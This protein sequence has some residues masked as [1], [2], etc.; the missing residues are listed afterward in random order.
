MP[1]YV[2]YQ[3]SE[4][5]SVWKP[6]PVSQKEKTL[7]ATGAVFVTALSVSK[8]VD[9]LEP[10]EKDKLAYEGP[11]YLDWDDEND[12]KRVVMKANETLDKFAQMGVNL[13]SIALYATGKKGFHAEIPQQLFMEKLP[14]GGIIGLP[15]I[16]KEMV[17]ELA[18]D[19]LDLTVYSSGHGRMWRIPNVERPDNGRFKV[20]LHVEEIRALAPT[21]SES[22][23][24]VKELRELV[25]TRYDA[26]VSAQRPAI[27]LAAPE[28][29]VDLH[30]LFAGA[31]QK[32]EERLA[33]RAKRKRD[34]MAK[35]KATMPSVRLMMAGRGIK[36][37]TGFH[38]LALQITIAAVAANMK[39]DD[40]IE[41]CTSLIA[42]YA[43][44]GTRYG[45]PD[46]RRDELLRLYD[47]MLDNPGY[48]FS[49]GAIKSILVHEAPDLDN[50]PVSE[51]E[52]V[53]VIGEAEATATSDAVKEPEEYDDVTGGVTMSRYGVYIDTENGKKRVCAV[54]FREVHL[55]HSMDTGSICAYEAEV[56]VNGKSAGRHTMEMDTFASISIF[57]RFLS[58][59]GHAM[60]GLEPHVRG[61]MMRFVEEG[62]KRG[63]MLYIAKREGLDLV[64]IPNHTDPDLREPFMVYAAQSGVLLDPRVQGK[65]LD[66]SFQGFPDPR[67]V[68]KTDLADA[69]PLTAWL[70]EDG[71]GNKDTL[72]ATLLAMMSMQKP[73]VVVKMIGWYVACFYRMI[74][75]KAYNKFPLMHVNGA[76]GSGKTE[77]ME[78]LS[79]FF[80]YNQDPKVTSPASTL[81]A[82]KQYIAASASVPLV[83]D[84]YKPQDMPEGFHN[85]IRL[86]FRDAYNCRDVTKGGGTRESDDYRVLQS[87]QLS[88]PIA[89]IAEAAE[90]ESAVAERI[91]LVTIVKPPSSVAQRQLA[92]FNVLARN[93][94]VLG[95]L[96]QYLAT[97]TIAE[98][99]IAKLQEEFDPIFT[100]A[101]S[102]FLLNDADLENGTDESELLAKSSAKERSVFNYTVVRFGFMKFR[103]LIEAIY[104]KSEFAELMD[105][106]Q[107]SVYGRMSDLN[108]ATQPEWAKVLIQMAD[109]SWNVDPDSTHALRPTRE[110]AMT[111]KGGHERLELNVR[112]AYLK[113]RAYA[114]TSRSKILFSGDQQF[115]YAMKDCPALVAHGQGEALQM[116]NIFTF[117][118]KRL[119]EL[120]VGAFK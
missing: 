88:A 28:F 75:H 80:F 23:L 44:A 11:F 39:P 54:S 51:A 115:I 109:M 66:I 78:A 107:A 47:Y 120:G 118:V 29:N 96:G 10:A 55:L 33:Q 65:T 22:S 104:G 90:E 31:K 35:Q 41:A 16:Y 95:I 38:A 18:I 111:A 83:I 81:F 24:P 67:G 21:D 2:Y 17:Y 116:P 99:G 97:Q 8:I 58:R 15:M 5:K 46:K 6:V 43:D 14:K 108:A 42:A 86:V 59:F 112:I 102:K 53:E 71:K 73:E 105:S 82:I 84:E 69:P 40:M 92:H 76:A 68:Y 56:T 50:L 12:I 64:N 89:F 117:D 72:R 98:S 114:A 48:E 119:K 100:E 60:Q 110:Y 20:P 70:K 19:T 103:K 34:P 7:T 1:N 3:G 87:T 30:L 4:K 25:Q 49:V 13:D 36:P 74:F 9:G 94:K 85:A 32:V 113:Y 62:K 101:K 37:G 61:L 93:K 26:L 57:N 91:V 79:H 63:K 27:L 52:I 45:T 77:M 106:L